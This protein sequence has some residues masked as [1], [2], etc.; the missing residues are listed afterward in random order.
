MCHAYCV[1]GSDCRVLNASSKIIAIKLPR[2]MGLIFEEDKARNR[3]VIGDFVEG[4]VAEQRNKVCACILN[5]GSHLRFFLP[6]VRACGS[7]QYASM[8]REL[9]EIARLDFPVDT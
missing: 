2:P 3:V 1:Q 8:S 9:H 7:W 6:P 5:L 4:S